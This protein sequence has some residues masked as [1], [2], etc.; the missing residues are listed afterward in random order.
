MIDDIFEKELEDRKIFRNLWVL[1]PHYVPHELPHREAE[2]RHITKFIAP[3]LR[4]EKPC[5]IFIYGLTGTGKTCTSKYVTTKLE[6]LVDDPTKNPNKVKVRIVYVNCRA[7]N[8]KYQVLMRSL[9]D[10]CL[11]DESLVDTPLKDREND[12]L[13][14]LTPG[15]LYERLKKVVQGNKLNF[16]MILDEIDKVKDLDDLMYL[17]TRINDE[18]K[19]G[20]VTILGISNRIEVKNRLDPR[21][22]SS[23]YE[24]EIVF[25]PYNAE[26]LTT[27]LKQRVKIGLQP[28]VIDDSTI[29]LI[30]AFA[31][32]DG[33]ARYTLRLLQ[34]SGELAQNVNRSKIQI[35][36]VK[37]AKLAVEVDRVF[38]AISILPE[39]Q[40]IVLYSIADIISK[41]S[42]YKKLSDMPAGILFSGEVY[43]SY[44]HF[45][46][47]F[48]RN[49]RT[50]RWFR[51]YLNELEMLGLITLTVSGKGIRGNTTLIRL[52][53][54][55]KEVKAI[56]SRSL[57]LD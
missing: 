17:L 34:K 31:A 18:L 15:E 28:D 41:G 47:K 51:E 16:I 36:D 26:Q 55:P 22:K 8:K 57:G 40:Q 43:E 54:D 38:E 56:V 19:D 9:E 35:E 2:A 1:S 30:A 46:R 10:P 7:H 53:Y 3:V 39:H 45:C 25:K 20:H 13:L 50:T 29:E 48:N 12:R 24:E 21:S 42:S 33:D 44:E 11:N 27:I 6:Q 4:N 23:L 49:P 14:G 32:Q 37:K 5:N 52:G